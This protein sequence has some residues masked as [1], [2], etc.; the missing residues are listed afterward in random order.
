MEGLSLP[1]KVQKIINSFT[2]GLK[3]IYGDG[4]ISVILYGSAAS[5]EYAG[6]HSNINLAIILGDTSLSS[7]RKAAQF[8]NKNKFLL[9]NPMFFTEDYIKKSTDVFPIEY[10]DIKENHAVLYGKDVFK[11]INIDIRNL[12][13]QCEQ[14]LKSKILNIKKLYLR[15]KN[16]FFLKNILFKSLTSSIHILRNL[17]RLEGKAPSYKK[18][19]VLDEI[20]REFSADVSCLRKILDAKNKNKRLSHKDIDELFDCFIEA[21]ENI[22]DKVNRL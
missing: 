16:K 17:V 9:I 2:S 1:H 11:D 12:R 20:S 3:N 8:I 10:L 6:R 19:D 4:L 21:L 15:T 5:G 22:S 13:F 7:I 14:E 18:E